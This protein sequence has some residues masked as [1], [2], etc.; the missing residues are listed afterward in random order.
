MMHCNLKDKTECGGNFKD[1]KTNIFTG[2]MCNDCLSCEV[3]DNGN[4]CNSPNIKFV[5][6]PNKNGDP[7]KKSLCY[8]CGKTKIIKMRYSTEWKT[9]PI[10]TVDASESL[11]DIAFSRKQDFYEYVKRERQIRFDLESEKRRDQY[12]EYLKSDQW[13]ALRT[14]VLSR[15]NFICQSCLTEKAAEVHHLTYDNLFNEH[16]FELVSLCKAC[17]ERIHDK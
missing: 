16:A 11:K 17:H 1:F 6:Q 5:N 14:K 13:R 2:R 3:L 9:L 8:T 4:C 15:D 7:I 12:N 10:V